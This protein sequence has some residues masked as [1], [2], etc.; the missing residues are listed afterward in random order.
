MAVTIKSA[1]SSV[2]WDNFGDHMLRIY[3]GI[4]K[5]V[6]Y[7]DCELILA[8]GQLRASRMVLGMASS[9][10]ETIFAATSNQPVA[11]TE[12]LMVLIPDLTVSSMRYVLQFIYM[13]EVKLRPEDMPS[14]LDA[15]YLLHI[16]GLKSNEGRVQGASITDSNPEMYEPPHIDATNI[17]SDPGAYLMSVAHSVDDGSNAVQEAERDLAAETSFGPIGLQTAIAEISAPSFPISEGTVAL[18]PSNAQYYDV[19]E[20]HRMKEVAEQQQQDDEGANH[21][22]E[23]GN[24]SCMES[25]VPD[26]MEELNSS[27]TE[28]LTDT[29]AKEP[30]DENS[31]ASYAERLEMAIKA[32]VSCGMSFRAASFTYN[33]PKTVLWR[34]TVKISRPVKPQQHQLPSPR[35]DAI[36][37]IKAGEKL[38]NVSR[39]FDIPISTLHRDKIR[40]YSEG[41]LPDTVALKQRDKGEKF[42]QRVIEAAQKCLDGAMSLSEAARAYSLPKTTIWRKIGSL[43]EKPGNSSSGSHKRGRT[44][45]GTKS[46]SSEKNSVEGCNRIATKQKTEETNMKVEHEPSSYV[47]M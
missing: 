10:F 36:E 45:R 16:R 35:R 20:E 28:D 22:D 11:V 27:N 21:F 32:V 13:G 47:L 46:G 25:M 17:T 15:C 14:F 6:Q 26:E 24:L 42:K 44:K 5:N 23:S 18:E 41:E 34:K 29:G 19:I 1:I 39:R 31:N 40:L 8:D 30:S 37:A 9:F 38:L 12:P 43:K 7:T 2:K 33:I 3:T 4:Y